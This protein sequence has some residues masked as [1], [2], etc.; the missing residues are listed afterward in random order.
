[1]IPPPRLWIGGGGLALL[2]WFSTH[3]GYILGY[4]CGVVL[5][6]MRGAGLRLNDSQSS[7]T[8]GR[9]LNAALIVQISRLWNGLEGHFQALLFFCFARLSG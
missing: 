6:F 8:I 7:G 2:L 1:M 3:F 4:N 9:E 5:V